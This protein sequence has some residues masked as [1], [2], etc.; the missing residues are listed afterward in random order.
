MSEAGPQALAHRMAE[1]SVAAGSTGSTILGSGR[2]ADPMWTA[3]AHGAA[4]SWHE[5]DAG[6]RFSGG[7]PALY[8][9]SAGLPVA[10]REGASGKRLLE[11]VIG[12]YEVGARIGLGTTLRP[13]MDPHGSWTVVASAATASL[14]TGTDLRKTI[15]LVTSFNLATSSKAACEGATIRNI[16][17]GFGSAMGV[18]ATDLCRDGFSAE[19]DGIGTVFGTIAGV[20]FDVE[21]A[22][23]RIGD[24]WE[25][26][27]GYY[28]PYACSRNIHPALDGLIALVKDQDITPGEIAGIEVSTY[29][30]AALNGVAT[31]AL[32][33]GFSMPYALASYLVL[34]EAGPPAYRQ[35]ALRNREIEKLA[36]KVTVKEDP[37]MNGRTPLERPAR[38][39]L[40]LNNGKSVERLVKLPRG[41]SDS[42]PLSDA[43]LSEKFLKLTSS[44]LGTDRSE[45]LLDKLWHIDAVNDL[46]EVMILGKIEIG[47]R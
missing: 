10:E 37:E 9:I 42:D 41:E 18:L 14:L 31:G 5:F 13:G 12:G 35:E 11:S 26:G 2:T 32:T 6:N 19:R 34:K 44:L 16:Y 1:A 4:G 36:T 45:K 38:V 33:P 29:A 21:K 22:L 30:M 15:N 27:R 25:I 23:D 7:H 43:E 17:A 46:R 3:L 28:K 24:R 8:S 40:H 47:S 39:M 20:F